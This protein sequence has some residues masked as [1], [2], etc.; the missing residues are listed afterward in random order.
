MTQP[1]VASSLESQYAFL[2]DLPESLLPEVI[3]L[4]SGTLAERV[5]GVLRWRRALLQGRLPDVGA[6]PPAHL[7][8]PARLAFEQLGIARFCRDEPTLVDALLRDLLWS[9]ADQS[10]AFSLEV[11]ARL[12]EL[13][14]LERKRLEDEEEKRARREKRAQRR[15]ELS[16]AARTALAERA[17][18]ALAQRERRAEEP[19]LQ[20]WDERV[21]A[22][23]S[24]SEVF[25]DLGEM[26]GRGWDLSLGVLRNVGWSEVLRLRELVERLPELREV[27]R[28]LGRLHSREKDVSVAELVMAPIRRVEEV[29][30]EV[31]APH[32]P[33]ETRGVER[34]AELARMLPSEA[35]MLGHPK[36]RLLWHARRAERAL[37]T[38]RVEGVAI[39]RTL[40]ERES[41]AQ[42]ERKRPG[43]ERGPIIVVVDTSG[44]MHGVPEQ[45]AKALVLEAL[46]TAHAERRRAFV[47]AYSGPGQILE[48]ELS[49]TPD[50]LG[51]L[52][53]FL[54][55]TF[56][57]GSD[58]AGVVQRVL[59]RLRSEHWSK[60]DVMYVSDGEWPVSQ[61]LEMS[62][63]AARKSGT[64]FHGVQVGNVGR[65]GLHRLCDP[66]HVFSTWAAAGGWR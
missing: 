44:S 32:V 5:A 26:L 37:L 20:I 23:A 46:R 65:T 4:P 53:S 57:G 28:A 24:I 49:L 33:A 11:S 47:Y 6:W 56:G 21:R 45:V 40:E 34:S 58:E 29:R 35:L 59:E 10:R 3:T 30:R 17:E 36:L 41:E 52:L 60:A 12:R 31:Q 2:D 9:V 54:G 63:G 38:Y 8:A 1:F 55:F 22:W 66:V 14:Q 16:E 51:N 19:I 61:E 18:H 15:I 13:E 7:E 62:I 43:Q 50:G 39:E 25:G 42:I 48:H 27:V 64:R